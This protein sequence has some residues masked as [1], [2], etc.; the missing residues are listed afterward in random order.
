MSTTRG[1]RTNR[2]EVFPECR[3][4]RTARLVWERDSAPS[5]APDTSEPRRGP[6]N[7]VSDLFASTN[8]AKL[9]T[10]SK[11]SAV[12]YSSSTVQAGLARR[13]GWTRAEE[14]F[15]DT[16]CSGSPGFNRATKA[17]LGRVTGAAA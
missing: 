8:A 10:V 13:A 11:T 5:F 14:A 7:R 16:R 9:A 2:H 12:T 6:A 1:P 17:S 15:A 3:V 4:A